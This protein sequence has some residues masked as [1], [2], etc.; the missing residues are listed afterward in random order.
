MNLNSFDEITIKFNKPIQ[1]ILGSNGAG[2]S[3]LLSFL[4]PLAGDH[5]DFDKGGLKHIWIEHRGHIYQGISD[6][7][8]GNKHTLIRDNEPLC[9]NANSKV[10]NELVYEHFHFTKEIRDLLLGKSKFT[11]MTSTERRYWFNQLSTTDYTFANKAYQFFKQ[12]LRDITGSLKENKRRLVFEQ[13][14]LLKEEEIS[15]IQKEVHQTHKEI[16]ELL[17]IRENP[18]TRIED[19]INQYNTKF[20]DILSSCRDI[21]LID[22]YNPGTFKNREELVIAIES[23]KLKINETQ[24]RLSEK[25][26]EFNKIEKEVNL[27]KSVGEN[28][29]NSIKEKVSIYQARINELRS[30][31][32]YPNIEI[33]NAPECLT[34][35]ERLE[36]EL[37]QL[38]LSIPNNENKRYSQSNLEKHRRELQS[39]QN[40]LL[41]VRDQCAQLNAKKLHLEEHKSK[42]H[43]K[44]PQ[45]SHSWI[46]DYDELTYINVCKALERN[47]G[48][49][50]DLE[51][52]EKQLKIE[53]E[54]FIEYG[55][56]I[57]HFNTIESSSQ[58]A[59]GFWQYIRMN[60]Y[61]TDSPQQI[62]SSFLKF[63]SDLIL[64]TQVTQL[65]K[66]VKELEKIQ[67][68]TEVLE[69]KNL[70]TLNQ[71]LESF[72]ID[73]SEL[74]LKQ[75]AYQQT[76]VKLQ[77]FLLAV[78][79]AYARYNQLEKILL[80]LDNLDQLT[81]KTV[82]FDIVNQMLKQKQSALAV[83]EDLL[84]EIN[85][86]KTRIGFL[87]EEINKGEKDREALEI[88]FKEISPTEGLIAEG[89]MGFI[90]RF[91]DEMNHVI[92]K[93]W[94][95]SLRISGCSL[96]DDS[97]IDLD[98]KFPLLITD[99]KDKREDISQGSDGMKEIIDTAFI[100]VAMNFLDFKDWPIYLD[101]FAKTFDET[102]RKRAIYLIKSLMENYS[103]TQ[104]FMVSHYFNIHGAI[105]NAEICVLN[106]ENLNV[107][108]EYN[109]HV[110]F[111]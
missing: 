55:M 45:C 26:S 49:I 47:A 61:L 30:N 29:L 22:Q 53:I 54:E 7:T 108:G 33:E 79:E 11:N 95:Y 107:M 59:R 105:S 110:S 46:L 1:Q 44:C 50:V 111:Q 43:I 58:I 65:E 4:N 5:K 9:E 51:K 37:E 70:N 52:R 92:S 41:R 35:M 72:S 23:L 104:L 34:I 8:H 64:E 60:R 24:A 14:K 48:L 103:F 86:Q 15:R 68:M 67:K 85:N 3:T 66:D 76:S 82:K 77:T 96:I 16:T 21:L 84:S 28:D 109:T 19:L 97:S 81:L 83:K 10:Y 17:E 88:L 106:N 100:L 40:D 31:R 62:Q 94:T 74:T 2:K 39:V 56:K 42:G 101:E 32:F 25:Q 99:S 71:K 93:V 78:D 20:E 18:N 6:F 73:I 91:I 27:L 57:R 63:K 13:S 89:M 36:S 12:R 75:K 69:N 98:Y 80:D 38:V 90:N 102:H 87:S